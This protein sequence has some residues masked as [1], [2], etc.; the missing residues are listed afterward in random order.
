MP[1][2]RKEEDASEHSADEGASADP[3][4]A[5]KAKKAT[6]SKKSDE[7]K[8]QS[9]KAASKK[10]KG[11]V[12]KVLYSNPDGEKYID[13]GKKRRITVRSFKGMTQVDIRE[14]YGDDGDEKPGKKGIALSPEQW[15]ELKQNVATIDEMIKNVK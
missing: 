9:S 3:P 1:P 10:S 11:S 12:G 14:F 2:K 8:E 13:L 15:A 4:P 5:K 7:K 6:T